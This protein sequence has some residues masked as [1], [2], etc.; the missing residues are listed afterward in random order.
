MDRNIVANL[1]QNIFPDFIQLQK[2][3]FEYFG[4]RVKEYEKFLRSQA[5]MAS[6][7][8]SMPQKKSQILL[9][10]NC[11]EA[12]KV[13]IRDHGDISEY[14]QI[15]E[16]FES[17]IDQ[18]RVV[19][20]SQSIKSLL[21]FLQFVFQQGESC[22][23]LDL[24][25]KFAKMGGFNAALAQILIGDDDYRRYL[26]AFF[27][28]NLTYQSQKSKPIDKALAKYEDQ[29]PGVQQATQKEENPGSDSDE[30]ILLE[31]Q[32]QD[33][34][35]AKLSKYIKEKFQHIK[36]ENIEK[37]IYSQD[38]NICVSRNSQVLEDRECPDFAL[39]D[40]DFFDNIEQ[41]ERSCSTNLNR[42]ASIALDAYSELEI[43]STFQCEENPNLLENDVLPSKTY[44]ER[45]LVSSNDY[46]R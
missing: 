29:S 17:L 10:E 35:Y 18:F 40:L 46:M 39:E 7:K 28:Q 13:I 31:D 25:I 21:I 9:F 36:Q 43:E 44:I 16:L 22:E 4:H 42:F 3:V 38:N 32:K 5:H 26:R 23:G 24:R 37:F 33:R 30:E 6:M 14:L 12:L 8:P 1:L 27:R 34:S 41:R 20:D 45:L 2:K 19:S 15:E 11:L